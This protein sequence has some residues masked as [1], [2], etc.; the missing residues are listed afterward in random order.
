[1][2]FL[3]A[4]AGHT[5]MRWVS[6]H[7]VNMMNKINVFRP[8]SEQNFITEYIFIFIFYSRSTPLHL[9]LV[10]KAFYKFS[11]LMSLGRV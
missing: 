3:P 7:S 2:E 11:T 6:R 9:V 8:V 5:A 10:I 1:M 4:I